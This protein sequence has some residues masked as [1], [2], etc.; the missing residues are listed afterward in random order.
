M[1]P[2][3]RCFNISIGSSSA[4]I[5]VQVEEVLKESGLKLAHVALLLWVTAMKNL[6]YHGQ[7]M[8]QFEK[9]RVAQ[10]YLE[11]QDPKMGWYVST[12]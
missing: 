1:T 9:T 10:H 2:D 3:G 7:A 11:S 8:Q 4:E 12:I 5:G 6:C